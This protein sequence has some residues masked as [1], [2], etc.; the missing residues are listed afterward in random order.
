M[1]EL[2]DSLGDSGFTIIR[3]GAVHFASTSQT[4]YFNWPVSPA[5]QSIADYPL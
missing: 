3:D 4:V 1:L 2:G 5:S